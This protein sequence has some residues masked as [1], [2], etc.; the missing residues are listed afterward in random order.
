MAIPE[1]YGIVGTIL[2]LGVIAF[3]I[4]PF[5]FKPNTKKDDAKQKRDT[6]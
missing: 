1:W 2:G 5:I 3:F 4:A 6:K